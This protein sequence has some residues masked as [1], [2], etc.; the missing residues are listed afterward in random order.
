MFHEKIKN[1]ICDRYL[2]IQPKYGWVFLQHI[3]S[4]AGSKF[5]CPPKM[6]LERTIDFIFSTPVVT[7]MCFCNLL[8]LHW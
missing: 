1:P 2:S 6:L 5:S 3:F 8:K 4:G 7:F